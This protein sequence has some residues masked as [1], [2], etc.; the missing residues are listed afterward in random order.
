M[1]E[2]LGGVPWRG[3]LQTFWLLF[4]KGASV[5]LGVFEEVSGRFW[6]LYLEARVMFRCGW[7]EEKK[8]VGYH[9]SVSV[10][11]TCATVV[12]VQIVDLTIDHVQLGFNGEMTLWVRSSKWMKT[13]KYVDKQGSE[14]ATR[15]LASALSA[16]VIYWGCTD[17]AYL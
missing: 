3:L 8:P 6:S 5:H 14:Y 13:R 11:D 7:G 17:T 16:D 4:T 2:G 10:W 15:L 1:V 12:V 9:E